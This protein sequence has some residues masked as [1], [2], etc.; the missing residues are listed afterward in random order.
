MNATEM[1]TAAAIRFIE[2][3]NTA[4]MGRPPGRRCG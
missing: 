4:A 1:N 2:A 3:F